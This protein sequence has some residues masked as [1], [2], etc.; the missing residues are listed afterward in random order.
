V[1]ARAKV[2]CS[3]TLAAQASDLLELVFE[4]EISK[5]SA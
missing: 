5:T 3:A 1:G 4:D 2:L